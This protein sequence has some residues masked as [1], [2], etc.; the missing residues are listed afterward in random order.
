M[1]SN[2]VHQF[3]FRLDTR[4][5]KRTGPFFCSGQGQKI[6]KTNF[7]AFNSSKKTKSPI[8]SGRKKQFTSTI[9][10]NKVHTFIFLICPILDPVCLFFE[11]IEDTTDLF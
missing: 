4:P 2:F 5:F 8:L 11:R 7:L 6:S 1:Q 9:S 10:Y 3:G